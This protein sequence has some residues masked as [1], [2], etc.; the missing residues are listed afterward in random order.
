MFSGPC[1]YL[2]LWRFEYSQVK[3]FNPNKT[4]LF[5]LIKGVTEEKGDK[6]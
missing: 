4:E 5:V 1:D 3:K 6:V 2:F